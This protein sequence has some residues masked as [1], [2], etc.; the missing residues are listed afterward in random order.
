MDSRAVRGIGMAVALGS[1]VVPA[2]HAAAFSMAEQVATTGVSNTLASTGS[3]SASKTIG[4]VRSKLSSS[5]PSAPKL[6]NVKSPTGLGAGSPTRKR[7]AKGNSGWG[8]AKGWARNGKGGGGGKKGQGWT[9]SGG[10]PKADGWSSKG[11]SKA[12]VESGGGS[13][14][15]PGNK[16]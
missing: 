14:A 15:R 2:G 3:S 8:D 1:L 6:G 4:S 16:S 10:W 13:W 12:W 9:D 5:A 11:G 7:T